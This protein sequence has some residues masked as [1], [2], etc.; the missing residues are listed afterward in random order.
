MTAGGQ[1]T[2][3]KNTDLIKKREN[4][5]YASLKEMQNRLVDRMNDDFGARA[6]YIAWSKEARGVS[7]ACWAKGCPYLI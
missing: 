3:K 1:F 7:L 6:I 2:C 5:V 4:R